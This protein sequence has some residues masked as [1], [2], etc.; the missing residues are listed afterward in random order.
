MVLHTIHI[1]HNIHTLHT[2]HLLHNILILDTRY[3]T[4]LTHTY[5]WDLLW[6]TPKGN[7]LLPRKCQHSSK[8]SQDTSKTPLGIPWGNYKGKPQRETHYYSLGNVKK[9]LK[10]LSGH[11]QDTLGNSIGN[12]PRETPL[13][14]LL[15]S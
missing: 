9:L 11:L 10:T 4:Y 2:I 6:E 8:P 5:P 12:P 13:E 3:N 1:L 7:P 14:N 15:K